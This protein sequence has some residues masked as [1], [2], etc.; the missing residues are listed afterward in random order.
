MV[1]RIHCHQLKRKFGYFFYLHIL[2]GNV[3]TCRVKQTLETMC[4]ISLAVIGLFVKRTDG[5]YLREGLQPS[6]GWAACVMP[7]QQ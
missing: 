2:S 3:Y 7:S 1:L 4:V 5:N 6:V